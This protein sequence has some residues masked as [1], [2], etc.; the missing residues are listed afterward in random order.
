MP[1]TS[2]YSAKIT[3]YMAVNNSC[4]HFLFPVELELTEHGKIITVLVP[5]ALVHFIP[6]VFNKQDTGEIC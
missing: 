1:H 2:G 6:I 4:C 3:S 5:P